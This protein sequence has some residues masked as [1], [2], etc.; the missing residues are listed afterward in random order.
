MNKIWSILRI[1]LGLLFFWAFIDKAFGLGYATKSAS[2]WINGGSPTSGFL[3]HTAGPFANYFQ[4]L[5]GSPVIDW[6]FMLSLF[7]L[8]LAL[9][10]GLCMKLAGWGGTAL[11]LLMWASLLPV[12]NH[13]FIDEHIIYAFALI[14]LATTE[15]GN[16]WSFRAWWRN[17]TLVQNHPFLD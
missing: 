17:T 2:A 5:A 9:I 4:T 16:S 6:L 15:T 12:E 1:G 10:F 8:G 14:G 13:P 3:S 11:M 7:C